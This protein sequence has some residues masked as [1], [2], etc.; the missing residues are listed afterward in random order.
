MAGGS[1]TILG[2]LFGV[3]TL[4]VLNNGMNMIGVDDFYQTIITG[5]L[6]LFVMLFDHFYANR[7][8]KTNLK[9]EKQ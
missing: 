3:L 9:L 6:L 1:G 4:G 5:A 7:K 8:S 2:T